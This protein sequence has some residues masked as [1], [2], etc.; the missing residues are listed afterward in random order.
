M[1]YGK[2]FLAEQ[3]SLGT[4]YLLDYKCLKKQLKK[5]SSSRRSSK[6]AAGE[7]N[8]AEGVEPPRSLE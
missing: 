4:L 3:S 1:K 2:R 6:E 8:Q 5:R 7:G